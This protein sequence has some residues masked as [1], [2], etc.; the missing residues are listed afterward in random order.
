MYRVD[1]SCGTPSNLFDYWSRDLV[2]AREK[3][4]FSGA[5]SESAYCLAA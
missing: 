2:F 4:R 1:F 5:E 3:A